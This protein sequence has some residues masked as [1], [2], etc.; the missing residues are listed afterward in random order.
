MASF[1]DD[2]TMCNETESDAGDTEKDENDLLNLSLT[3]TEEEEA[4]ASATP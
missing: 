3:T 2:D 4:T 1:S